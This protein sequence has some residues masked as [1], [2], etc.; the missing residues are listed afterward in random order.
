ME[1]EINSKT[2][3]RRKC[4]EYFDVGDLCCSSKESQWLEPAMRSMTIHW[5][6]LTLTN[7]GVCKCMSESNFIIFWW[8]IYCA[9]QHRFDCVWLAIIVQLI[10]KS[11]GRFSTELTM[12][13][14]LS[15]FTRKF[16]CRQPRWVHTSEIPTPT[17][18]NYINHVWLF[19]QLFD[20]DHTYESD[21]GSI[22]W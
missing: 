2:L 21:R 20:N 16:Y 10:C 12:A 13:L 1:K 5:F 22:G 4:R 9:Q 15:N 18:K 6:P 19:Q 7:C 14:N 3:G 17:D 11:L 8:K